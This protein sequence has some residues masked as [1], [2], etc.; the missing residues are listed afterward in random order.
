[1]YVTREI[2][3]QAEAQFGVPDELRMTYPITPDEL[4][5]IRRSQRH[6]RAHDVTTL[7]LGGDQL[8][9]IAKHNYPPGIYR[10]PGGGLQPGEALHDGA[11][12]EA[13]EET[14]LPYRIERY[15]LRVYV[16]FT[17]G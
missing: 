17:C 7:M 11:V 14:G 6:G 15:L 4:T 10:V 12:R 3:R 13:F 8:A 2:I 5:M 16:R 1:M 9:A